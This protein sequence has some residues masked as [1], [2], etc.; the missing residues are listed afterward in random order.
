MT[1][2]LDDIM[3]TLRAASP[4]ARTFI[5][6][7]RAR[8]E[9]VRVFIEARRKLGW[10]QRDLA[11]ESGVAQPVIARFE[12]CVTDPKIT[13]VNRLAKALGLEVAARPM[14]RQPSA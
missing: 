7:E 8:T 12:G 5:D 3:E 11:R 14:P 9:F 13:T 6:S 4:E 1:D 2:E 10:T